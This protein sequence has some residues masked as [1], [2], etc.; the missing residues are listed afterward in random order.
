MKFDAYSYIYFIMAMIRTFGLFVS[1][2]LPLEDDH[3]V[4]VPNDLLSLRIDL[5]IGTR[6]VEQEMYYVNGNILETIL[7]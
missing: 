7:I 6:Y 3:H 5:Q 2:I 1:F 4:K